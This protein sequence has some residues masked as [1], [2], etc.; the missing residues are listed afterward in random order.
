MMGFI[1]NEHEMLF[2]LRPIGVSYRC[3]LCERGE[4]EVDTNEALTICWDGEAGAHKMPMRTHICNNCHGTM[5]LPK[6]YPY[7]EW[8]TTEEYT[9]FINSGLLPI[10]QPMMREEE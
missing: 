6:T 10:R 1:P 4:M 3:E 2:E 5:K 7:I 8:V 9:R